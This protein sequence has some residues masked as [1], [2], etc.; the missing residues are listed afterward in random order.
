[1]TEVKEKEQLFSLEVPTQET[2]TA[3]V[4]FQNPIKLLLQHSLMMQ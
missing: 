3:E 4:K 2:V 1:M